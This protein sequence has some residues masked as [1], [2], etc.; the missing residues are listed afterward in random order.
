M[1]TAD[2]LLRK[3]F[4]KARCFLFR[5]EEIEEDFYRP[6][7]ANTPWIQLTADP[8]FESRKKLWLAIGVSGTAAFGEYAP[9]DS[10]DHHV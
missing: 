8:S 1:Q 2:V 3:E 5:P 10:D 4:P 9:G 7:L 6:Y